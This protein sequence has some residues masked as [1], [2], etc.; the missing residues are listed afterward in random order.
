MVTDTL[1]NILEYS[2][3]DAQRGR[4]TKRQADI[5]MDGQTDE[6][7]DVKKDKRIVRQ[8]AGKACVHKDRQTERY[9]LYVQEVVTLQK[10]Y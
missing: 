4:Q 7:I 3:T 9:I 2:Q 5:W 8:A 6:K 1:T 10:K